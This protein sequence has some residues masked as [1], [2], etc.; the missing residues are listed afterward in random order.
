METEVPAQLIYSPSAVLNLF[1]NSISI[2][3][4]KRMIQLKGVFLQ[5]RTSAY[6]GYY[7]DT[8]RDES[9]DAQLTLI[10]PALIRGELQA[11]K[12]ITVNG[13]ITKRVMNSSGSIQIQLTVTDLV[14]QT[15]NKYSE[16][17][18]AKIALL[19]AKASVGFRDV[20]GFIKSRIIN[21]DRFRIAV[22]IGKSGIIDSDIKH[23]LK[24]SAA[25]F[26]LTFFRVNLTSESE[27][28]AEMKRLD[29]LGFDIIAVSRGGGEM[30]EIF[31]KLPV[32]ER[33]IGLRALFVTAIGHK[34][35]VSL[36]QQVADK[37][38]ITPTAFGTF[39]NETYNQT[40]EEAAHS[41]AKLVESVKTQLSANYQKQIDNLNDKLKGVEE[42]KTGSEKLQQEK[43]VLMNEQIAA[44]RA[45]L[46][47]VVHKPAVNWVYVVAAIVIGLIIGYLIKR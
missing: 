19:Q 40:V 12:T 16:D 32:A 29:A 3:Q 6:N 20:G 22:I 25:F 38:F 17:D 14:E 9:S 23:Q 21:E 4:S 8:L 1:N 11:N 10:V 33:S 47:A 15:Q 43:L 35:D 36:L 26:D 5:G 42:L 34:D 24:E 37:A 31:N 13:F 7:Y 28:T 2:T 27:L 46:E 44:Y 41:K 45:Q 30:M 18:L 39:L